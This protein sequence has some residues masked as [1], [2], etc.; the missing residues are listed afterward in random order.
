M[1]KPGR[2]TAPERRLLRSLRSPER[3]QESL[4]S[5]AYSTDHFARCP[6]EVIRDRK[7]TCFDG[8]LFAAAALAEIGFPP[9]LLDLRAVRDDD[10]ILAV[11]R[12]N[13]RFGAVA[14]SNFVGLRFREPVYKTTRELAMSYFELYFNLQGE[15]TMREYSV[16]FDLSTVD[17]WAWRTSNEH[18]DDISDRLDALRHYPLLSPKMIRELNPIDRRTYKANILGLDRR[19]AYRA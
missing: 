13:G 17:R 10:H 16:L 14:K 15:K 6:R 4:D 12:R 19:G 3:I 11:F 2:W 5:I 7:A 9:L 1:A 18:M 8:A